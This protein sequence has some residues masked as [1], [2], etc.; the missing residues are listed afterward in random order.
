MR[1]RSGSGYATLVL[2]KERYRELAILEENEGVLK[3]RK[4]TE[5]ET[6]RNLLSYFFL[7]KQKIINKQ[8]E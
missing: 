1:V 3:E 6:K 5:T 2:T 8:R 7:I 4:K